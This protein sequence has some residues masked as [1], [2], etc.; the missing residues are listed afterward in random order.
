MKNN[1]DLGFA[2]V[3]G[4]GDG[5]GSNRSYANE[6]GGG[7]LSMHTTIGEKAGKYRVYAYLWHNEQDASREGKRA[8]LA[9]RGESIGAVI[10]A[11][12]ARAIAA[13]WLRTGVEATVNDLTEMCAESAEQEA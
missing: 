8:E 1:K 4:T 12:R 13:G 7:S 6:K 10:S 3:F 2:P 9:V 5:Y 11:F